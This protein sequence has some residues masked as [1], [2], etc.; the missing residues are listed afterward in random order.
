MD[1]GEDF[2]KRHIFLAIC[3]KISEKKKTK[4]L[5]KKINK[6]ENEIKYY[7]DSQF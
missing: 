1:S 6:K 4:P 5:I 7:E 2:E 3:S